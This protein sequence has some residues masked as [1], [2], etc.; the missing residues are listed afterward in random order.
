MFIVGAEEENVFL[1]LVLQGKNRS[2]VTL[3]QIKSVGIN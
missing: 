1:N 3:D 2:T